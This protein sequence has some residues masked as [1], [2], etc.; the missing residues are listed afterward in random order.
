M[1]L[2]RK[3]IFNNKIDL[4][5]GDKII[6]IIELEQELS[7]AKDLS[8]IGAGMYSH[9]YFMYGLLQM[10]KNKLDDMRKAGPSD[11]FIRDEN[12]K[13][14]DSEENRAKMSLIELLVFA[15]KNGGIIDYLKVMGYQ[16][17]ETGNNIM[18][19]FAGLALGITSPLWIWFQL[20]WKRNEYRK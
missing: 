6:E 17:I 15:A 2:I 16:L 10:Q 9:Q 12:N 7:E 3:A 5:I 11:R 8:D 20:W 19:F 13:I 14:I 1:E 4:M 18:Y